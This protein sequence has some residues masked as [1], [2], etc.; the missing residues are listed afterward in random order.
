MSEAERRLRVDLGEQLRTLRE[1]RGMSRDELA[2]RCKLD[3][4]A[5]KAFEEGREAP[6]IGEL[7]RIAPVLRVDLGS[8]FVRRPASGPRLEIVRAA[9]RWDVEPKTDTARALN[10]RYQALS[11]SLSDKAMFPFLVEIPPA[12]AG[13]V[14]P[15]RHAGE[16]FLFVLS[17]QLDFEIGGEHHRLGPGDSVYFDSSAEHTL[18]AA[19]GTAVRMVACV[20]HAPG[21]ASGDDL[22]RAFGRR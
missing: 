20:A 15:S 6:A 21:S 18:R 22:E 16:E 12:Q 14:T 2:S 5:L 3:V 8:F 17:G 11:Y 1:H 10:Y 7:A 19:E 4:A 13:E 9:Q